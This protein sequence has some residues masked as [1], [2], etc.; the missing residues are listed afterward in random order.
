M[1]DSKLHTSS[2]LFADKTRTVSVFWEVWAKWQRLRNR[3]V[4]HKVS[5]ESSLGETPRDVCISEVLGKV[6]PPTKD[7]GGEQPQPR[8]TSLWRQK[9]ILL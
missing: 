9:R 7:L 1:I 8:M 2:I 6:R 4:G 3:Y 5:A